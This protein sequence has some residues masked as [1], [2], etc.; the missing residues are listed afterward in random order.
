MERDAA[1]CIVSGRHPARPA[2]R[3][4]AVLASFG[5][6]HVPPDVHHGTLI[7]EARSTGTVVGPLD[8][9]ALRQDWDRTHPAITLS[10]D[11][12][13]PRLLF[14]LFIWVENPGAGALFRWLLL[15]RVSLHAKRRDSA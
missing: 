10:L 15:L 2:R 1:V 3:A 5:A 9:A 7:R 11:C 14:R 8:A 6:V 4:L 13:P 12:K